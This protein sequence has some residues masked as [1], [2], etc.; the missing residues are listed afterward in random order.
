MNTIPSIAP[1]AVKPLRSD[2]RARVSV[3]SLLMATLC[4]YS[5]I[6]HATTA[7]AAEA[8]SK[9]PKVPPAV[10]AAPASAPVV[11][12][13]AYL[14]KAAA[15]IDV[16]VN[17]HLKK[18]NLKPNAKIADA[19]YLRRVYVSVAGRIPT[20]HEALA[21]L[22]DKSPTRQSR[23]VEQLL[24]SNGYK[25]SM[26]NWYADMFRVTKALKG[27][28]ISEGAFFMQ[29]LRDS[30]NANKPWDKM[31]YEMMAA[32]GSYAENGAIG[33]LLKDSGM[34]LDSMT[35]TMTMFLGANISCAQC[36]DHPLNEWKQSDF[37]KMAAFF[38]TTDVNNVRMVQFKSYND[39]LP[40][41]ALSSNLHHALPIW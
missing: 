31:V 24:A 6:A 40:Q 27:S 33:L 9:N 39:K 17:D 21:Y 18:Q 38:G 7:N 15:R 29:Y 23:L 16:L 11:I 12:D 32:D 35:N 34:P 5:S 20:E 3:S 36:H 1:F 41:H 4:V 2:Q 28:L 22:N 37:Y 25:S 14:A 30:L 13:A 26:F 8:I 10:P 19:L